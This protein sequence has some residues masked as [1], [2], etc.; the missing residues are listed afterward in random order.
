MSN[1][2]LRLRTFGRL[3]LESTSIEIPDAAIRARSRAVLAM[4]AVSGT[5]GRTK[6]DI[7]QRL[8]PGKANGLHSLTELESVL[9]KALSSADPIKD[10]SPDRQYLNPSVISSDYQDFKDAI[11][12]ER[13]EKAV[14]IYEGPFLDKF[15]LRNEPPGFCEWVKA[16]QKE[17]RRDLL[18][19]VVALAHSK[20][21]PAASKAWAKID[22]LAD[23][24]EL[25]RAGDY[26]RTL[27]EAGQT[28]LALTEFK[29]CSNLLSNRDPLTLRILGEIESDLAEL[30]K[31]VE[32]TVLDERITNTSTAFPPDSGAPAAHRACLIAVLDFQNKRPDTRY[33]WLSNALPD[34]ATKALQGMPGIRPISRDRVIRSPEQEAIKNRSNEGQLNHTIRSVAAVF[35]ADHLLWGRYEVQN[36]S[37]ILLEVLLGDADGKITLVEKQLEAELKQISS[38]SDTVARRTAATLL[39]LHADADPGSS[40]HHDDDLNA[41]ELYAHGREHFRAFTPE[42]FQTAEALYEKAVERDPNYVLANA[43]L[44][45]ISV[46]RYIGDAELDLLRAAIEHLNQAV[47]HQPESSDPFRWLAYAYSRTGEFEKARRAA[48]SS[49]TAAPDD[50]ESYYFLGGVYHTAAL[51]HPDPGYHLRAVQFYRLSAGIE[52]KYYW[53]HIGLSHLYLLNG[54]HDAAEAI[55]R[56]ALPLA[57]KNRALQSHGP[58]PTGVLSVQGLVFL[59]K[60]ELDQAESTFQE[61]QTHYSAQKHL[62]DPHFYLL[63]TCGLARVYEARRDF[64]RALVTW[65]VAR[66]YLNQHTRRLGMEHNAIRIYLGLATAYLRKKDQHTADLHAASAHE[67]LRRDRVAWNWVWFGSLAESYLEFARYYAVAMKRES[68]SEFLNQA[69]R[70]GWSDSDS[71]RSEF[72][73]LLGEQQVEPF[74]TTINSRQKLPE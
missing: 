72:V 17:I 65:R 33:D 6:G 25:R 40:H 58:Q 70:W 11:S 15:T 12:N 24:K 48:H 54:Q 13:F 38:L 71:I 9:R 3:T 50:A 51:T 66:N 32:A 45:S 37:Q 39:Q 10:E 44:G 64:D 56:R 57:R 30:T 19:A 63:A 43:A 1:L 4:L 62:W 5:R 41:V 31:L 55:I 68:C 22:E 29:R 2:P 16:E 21:W 60:G 59:R 49:L 7:V 27:S 69:V 35:G 61:A 36:G 14:Q 73:P 20:K 26:L 47:R 23:E 28:S 18:H 8:W 67:Y 53:P 52:P 46:F 74:L 34:H 42:A